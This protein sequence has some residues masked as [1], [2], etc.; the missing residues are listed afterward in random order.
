MREKRKNKH[1]KKFRIDTIFIRIATLVILVPVIEILLFR[2]V[3]K[4]FLGRPQ[5]AP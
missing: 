1:H 2:L 5:T 4:A 3:G